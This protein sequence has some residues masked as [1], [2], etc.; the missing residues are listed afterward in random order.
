MTGEKL[1]LGEALLV[2]KEFDDMKVLG[3]VKNSTWY[4]REGEQQSVPNKIKE[5]NELAELIHS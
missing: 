1:P 3:K 4:E 5:M 2:D